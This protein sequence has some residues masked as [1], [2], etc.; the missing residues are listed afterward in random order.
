[1]LKLP[2]SYKTELDN[3]NAYIIENEEKYKYFNVASYWDKFFTIEDS[4]WNKIVRVSVGDNKLLGY[5][6]AS[7]S[8]DDNS[9]SSISILNF[10]LNTISLTFIKD[11]KAFIDYLLDYKK[12]RKIDF[13][14]VVDNPAMKLYDEFCKKYKGRVVGIR[15]DHVK[16][17]DGTY[18]DL[19]LY[20]VFRQE[21]DKEK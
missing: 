3:M 19:K 17:I 9:I 6:S 21:K 14:C 16:L 12:F 2:H 5:F 7:V 8:R 4:E 10:N 15:K 20:E 1:M 18:C 11:L 13:S